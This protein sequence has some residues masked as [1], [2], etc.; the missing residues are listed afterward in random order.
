ML[1]VVG[2]ITEH[3]LS[4]GRDWGQRGVSLEGRKMYGQ[5][6]HILNAQVMSMW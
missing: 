5:M 6:E 2:S 3:W 1:M 4:I